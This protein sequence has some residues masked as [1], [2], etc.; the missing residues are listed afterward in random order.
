MS[1]A[2]AEPR[3]ESPGIGGDSLRSG[4]CAATPTVAEQGYA[5]LRAV[6]AQFRARL[7]PSDRPPLTAARRRPQCS[8][9][10]QPAGGLQPRRAS[11]RVQSAVVVAL[12]QNAM[13]QTDAISEDRAFGMHT[14]TSVRI[15]GTTEE[16]FN[17][18][19]KAMNI[20]L[21]QEDRAR[22]SL[23]LSILRMRALSDAMRLTE[24]DAAI[25]ASTRMCVHGLGFEEIIA[26]EGALLSPE[27]RA[28]R[29]IQEAQAS[30]ASLTEPGASLVY[31][32]RASHL[33]QK[34]GLISYYY[35]SYADHVDDCMQALEALRCQRNAGARTAS[36]SW[37]GECVPQTR[38]SARCGD[39]VLGSTSTDA[40]IAEREQVQRTA[41]SRRSPPILSSTVRGRDPSGVGF[42]RR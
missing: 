28:L 9:T 32:D 24:D 8:L 7:R 21:H 5:D 11:G 36:N 41:W 37:F 30:Y 27:D 17:R 22:L 35:N 12:V 15:D 29:R 2:R 13:L 40:S 25:E 14:S 6:R 20:Q 26:R 38:R 33:H 10:T 4:R 31:A 39:R 19:L 3:A 42:G 16:S 18:S 23:A 1:R 34:W